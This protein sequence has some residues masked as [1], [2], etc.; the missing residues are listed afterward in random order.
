[1]AQDLG[2]ATTLQSKSP[3]GFAR[4]VMTGPQTGVT[5]QVMNAERARAE[6]YRLVLR[7]ELGDQFGFLF[8]GMR[9][10]RDDGNTVLTGQVA[11]QVHLTGIISRAQELGVE[12][13]SIGLLDAKPE[14]PAGQE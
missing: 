13:I 2:R 14:D 7:G 9:M 3:R 12:L 4:K 11:D 5:L 8:A 1:M 10:S 6:T